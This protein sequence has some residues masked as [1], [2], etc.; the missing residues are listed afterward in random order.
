MNQLNR[1]LRVAVHGNEADVR[2]RLLDNV[3]KE[4]VPRALRLEPYRL[5]PEEN[6]LEVLPGRVVRVDNGD[7]EYVSHEKRSDRP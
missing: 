6:R 2:L 4:R 1:A 5:E 3:D 7:P